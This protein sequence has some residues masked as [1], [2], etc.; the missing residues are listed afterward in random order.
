MNRPVHS[1]EFLFTANATLV[2]YLPKKGR[3]V[4]LMS[5]LHRGEG[6]LSDR[7][8][9]KPQI[10][11]DYNATK[12][13]V[14]NLDKVVA[15]YSCQRRTNR[16]PL[17]IFYNILDVSAYNSF[18]IWSELN[19]RWKQGE[20]QRRQHYLIELG[21]ALVTPLIQGRQSMPRTPAALDVARRMADARGARPGQR[22]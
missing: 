1:S 12:G 8:D 20:S 6:R 10:I 22:T 5:T 3:N 16:W 18:V 4:L 7:Q 17:V 2:S 21:K 14:D 15:C 9:Q 13:G 11:L 19:P